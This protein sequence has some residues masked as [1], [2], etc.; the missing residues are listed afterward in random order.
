MVKKIISMSIVSAFCEKKNIPID[1]DSVDNI[2]FWGQYPCEVAAVISNTSNLIVNNTTDIYPH[3][4]IILNTNANQP[5]TQLDQSV[6]SF[7]D[8]NNDITD[9]EPVYLLHT[10]S[11]NR[12]VDNSS[13]NGDLNNVSYDDNY[14]EDSIINLVEL[15]AELENIFDDD[16]SEIISEIHRQLYMRYE[17]RKKS[18]Q[19]YASAKMIQEC[20]NFKNKH[21]KVV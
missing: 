20:N 5:N 21:I 17:D 2:D 19:T 8:N 16:I 14:V 4:Q 9:C 12:C 6:D 7:I 13:I 3:A 10:D 15:G 18:F 1:T 11:N